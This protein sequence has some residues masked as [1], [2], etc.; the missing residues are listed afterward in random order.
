MQDRYIE[1]E[2]EDLEVI[3]TPL[4]LEFYEALYVTSALETVEY[5]LETITSD[6]LDA[7][8]YITYEATSNINYEDFRKK[9]IR[10]KTSQLEQLYYAVDAFWE[11]KEGSIVAQFIR[12]SLISLYCELPED[13]GHILLRRK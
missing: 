8:D 2:P 5:N 7:W 3:E 12:A 9:I 13:A 11:D 6:I 1:L 4:Y 10:A